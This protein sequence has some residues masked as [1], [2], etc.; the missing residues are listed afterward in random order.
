MAKLKLKKYPKPPKKTASVTVKEN[1][2]AKCRAIDKINAALRAE[3]KR[4][5]QLDKTIK[6]IVSSV[7]THPTPYTTVST[8]KY[9]RKKPVASK[10]KKRTAKKTTTRSKS[11]SRSRR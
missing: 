3:A 2:I 4:S 8:Q 9:K 11:R 1:F 10:T 5:E 7:T 6:G